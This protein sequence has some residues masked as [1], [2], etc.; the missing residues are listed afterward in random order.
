MWRY[1]MESMKVKDLMVPLDQYV[2]VRE[3]ATITDAILALEEAQAKYGSRI[4]P[5]RAVLV[6]DKDN[7]VI[8]KVGH[9]DILRS[10]E[11]RYSDLGDLKKVSGFGLS[12]EYMR[13]MMAEFDLW[14]APLEDLCHKAARVTLKSIVAAP[15]EGE[16]IESGA[17]L[18]QAVHQLIMGHHQSLLVTSG[19]R[20]VGMLR[21]A[22]V[23][24][25]VSD[26]IKACKV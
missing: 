7:K 19:D 12:A 22:D 23:Y 9:L 24:R 25:E 4:Y 1:S 17:T 13:S 14:K 15:V 6:C 26:R 5:Y 21:L 3:E 2:C 18:D 20:I 10:L 16:L 11:P 8:G